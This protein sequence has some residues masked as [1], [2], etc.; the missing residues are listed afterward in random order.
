MG[1][2]ARLAGGL[3]MLA[4]QETTVRT[5]ADLWRYILAGGGIRVGEHRDSGLTGRENRRAYAYLDRADADLGIDE[6]ADL[7][8][9]SM[10]AFGV[11][12]GDDLFAW[13]G[14]YQGAHAEGDPAESLAR[15][16]RQAPP[17]RA[18]H[19]RAVEVEGI[20]QRCAKRLDCRGEAVLKMTVLL[21]DGAAVWSTVPRAAWRLMR[22]AGVDLSAGMRSLL[23]GCRVRFVATVTRSPDDPTF[24]FCYRPRR[25]EVLSV[26]ATSA[27]RAA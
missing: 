14:E 5:N 7:I 22:G 27:E 2:G 26:P 4:L 15:E 8:A 6:W 18:P 3:T 21:D 13:L 17:I 20:V 24:G 12:C 10:P 16:L 25:F 9:T 1:L 19:G 11:T 23:P